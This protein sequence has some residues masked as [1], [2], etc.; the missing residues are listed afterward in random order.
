MSKKESIEQK[1]EA[2]ILPVL[3]AE[4]R[5]LVDT[6][7]VKEAGTYYLRYYIDKPLGVTIGDCE[8]VSRAVSDLLDRDD[9]ISE[10]YILEV[11]S[12]GL[13]RPIKKERDYVRNLGKEIEIR[14]F[15]PLKDR[16]EWVGTLASYTEDS[17]TIRS[18]QEEVIIEKKNI[19]LIREY[20]DFS[21]I[22]PK[23]EEF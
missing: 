23:E 12:P 17:V 20:V 11:S 21:K 3:E 8:T 6:E 15:K 14:L 4:G 2:L 19:S 5:E 13:G 7:Y 16:K 10:A 9:F 22:Q 1:A 18:E